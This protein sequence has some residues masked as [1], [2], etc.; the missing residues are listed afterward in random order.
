MR[1]LC[2]G[3]GVGFRCL[4]DGGLCSRVAVAHAAGS[5]CLVEV[6]CSRVMAAMMVAVGF[7]QG[8][9]PHPKFGC[10]S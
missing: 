10:H 2:E 9:L 7:Q 8:R 5:C 4:C 3:K 6:G 1:Q